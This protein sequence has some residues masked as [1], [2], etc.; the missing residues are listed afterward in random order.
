MLAGHRGWCNS[1][2]VNSPR[3]KKH[4]AAAADPGTNARSIDELYGLEPVFEPGSSSERECHTSDVSRGGSG[5]A[6]SHRVQCPYCGEPFDTLLD[7]STGS[8]V[9]T[10]DCQI[11]CQPIEFRLEVG[12]D[13]RLA[14]LEV[15]RGD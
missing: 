2:A 11:C 4:T 7:L 15:L 14:T 1:R 8:A 5:G 3:A 10:E 13:G 9:Y 6:Q 12:Y